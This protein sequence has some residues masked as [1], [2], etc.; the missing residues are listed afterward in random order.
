MQKYRHM[1]LICLLLVAPF[2]IAST[3]LTVVDTAGE[4]F[5]GAVVEIF[6]P[7]FNVVSAS[8][9]KPAVMEQVN[10]QFKP[11]ILIVRQNSQV[12]FP[13]SDSVKHHVYSF[14]KAKRFQLRLYKEQIPDPI[15]FDKDGV[16]AIGCN[17]H[18]WMSGFIYVAKSKFVKQT[19][20]QG[21]VT[22]E[23]P[24]G[25]Y[26]YQVW[27]PRF[28]E[29]DIGVVQNLDITSKQ[30]SANVTFKLTESLYPNITQD[31]D[32]FGDY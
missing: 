17:I 27:H 22:F 12:I 11:L 19:N 23:L 10:Q 14:S 24:P 6:H 29:A 1:F 25:N 28:N 3:E 16:V 13:N 4:P 8:T 2:C 7:N 30:D 5:S 15:T 31:A 20:Q 21:K 18:D 32:E 9:D 26:T